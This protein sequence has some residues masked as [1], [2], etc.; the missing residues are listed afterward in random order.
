MSDPQNP[1]PRPPRPD[2][3]LRRLRL[4]LIASV[5]VNVLVI[6]VLVGGAIRHKPF[7]PPPGQV[8]MRA[9]WRAMP[10][11]MRREMR[12]FVRER[13][14]GERLSREERRARAREVNDRLLTALRSEPFDADAFVALLEGDRAMIEQRLG[15]ANEAFT[16]QLAAMSPAQRRAMA[17]RLAEDWDEEDGERR[18]HDD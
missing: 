7:S 13:G 2:R 6:G 9:M 18:G 5:M 16:R 10:D 4:A 17:D 12:A 8:D 14:G 3:R 1:T 11:E 15:A